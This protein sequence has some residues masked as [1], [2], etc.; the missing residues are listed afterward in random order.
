MKK[1]DI[2]HFL[3]A[4]DYLHENGKNTTRH[5]YWLEYDGQQDI[6]CNEGLKMEWK[7]IDEIKKLELI[8]G[9]KNLISEALNLYKILLKKNKKSNNI[10]K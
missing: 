10:A 8:P 3:K 2:K 5:V 9:Q 6:E 7:T 4:E 1:Q